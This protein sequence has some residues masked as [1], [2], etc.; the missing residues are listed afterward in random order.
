MSRGID[1]LSDRKRFGFGLGLVRGLAGSKLYPEM[2]RLMMWKLL[3]KAVVD[4][5]NGSWS[6]S[7]ELGRTSRTGL[8]ART[9]A[10]WGRRMGRSMGIAMA[11]GALGISVAASPASLVAQE[12]DVRQEVIVPSVSPRD[13][14][15]PSAMPDRIVLSFSDDPQTTRSVN[16]RTSTEVASAFAE[17]AVADAGPAFTRHAVELTATT[18]RLSTDLGDAAFHSVTFRDLEPGKV[19]AYRVGDGTNWSEWFQFHMPKV[20][21]TKFS[22]VYFGD[23]QNDIR[24]MWS[25][26]IREAYA[27]APR[28]AFILHAGDLVNR[29]ESDGEWAEWFGAGAWLNAMTPT[30]A[31]PG[32]HEYLRDERGARRVSRHWQ[33]SFSLPENGVKG[34][35]ETNYTFV[36]KNMRFIALNSNEQLEEQKVWLAGILEN[37][38]AEWVVCSFH[39]P[40]YSTGLTRDNPELRNLWKPLFDQY[41][42]DLVLT[43]HDHTYGRTGFD[44][45]ALTMEIDGEDV[46]VQGS[47]HS[48]N[49]ASGQPH[50][51]EKT[52]TVYVVSVSGPKMYP[53][54]RQ[55]FMTR[56]AEDTQ[57]Y[58]VITIDGDSL[59]YQA[60]TATSELYDAFTLEKQG[61]GQVNRL[62]EQAPATPA[63]LRAVQE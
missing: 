9:S 15:A 29:P 52:G 57:L 4:S 41:K 23:A 45:P 6:D 46:T 42:V 58:Q 33:P 27:T 53:H 2:D 36:Y 8:E 26:V 49:V 63:R 44:V 11:Y 1:G 30:I 25:R 51:D 55:P 34:L 20:E 7:S 32:N 43:G 54:S 10:G 16:W 61:Q 38:K 47:T 40:V 22:F 50:F 14:Y 21:E 39:H 17:L 48:V 35:E 12:A 5:A 13:Y 31:V 18:S 24:S 19:Y 62:T 59:Q 3:S 28:S 60:F 37:N 56:I